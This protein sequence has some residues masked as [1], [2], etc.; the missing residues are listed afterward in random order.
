MKLDLS[1]CLPSVLG[2]ELSKSG[3]CSK[4]STQ[5]VALLD[6][7]SKMIKAEMMF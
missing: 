4:R 6:P 7:F 1:L 2:L 3:W 5:L